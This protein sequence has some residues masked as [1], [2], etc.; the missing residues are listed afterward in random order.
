MQLLRTIAGGNGHVPKFFKQGQRRIDDTGT[1]AVGAA[2][3]FLNGF[4]DFVTVPR[5]FRD[6]M[7]DNQSKVAMGEEAPKSG[8]PATVMAPVL[9]WLLVERMAAAGEAATVGVMV[10]VS[11]MHEKS[12]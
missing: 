8:P 7:E 5:L 3:V 1:G 12:D 4:D 2:D 9:D 10:R 6:E 11:W